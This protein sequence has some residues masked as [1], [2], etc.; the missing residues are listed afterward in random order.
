[1]SSTAIIAPEHIE[2]RILF[3]R[4]TRVML[5]Q[6]LAALYGVTTKAL[7]QAV[8]RNADRFPG[9]FMFR[10]SREEFD[11]LRSQSVTSSWGGRRYPPYA[12][13]EQGVAMLSAVLQSSR[14]VAV[15]IEIVRVFVRLRKLLSEHDALARKLAELETKMTDHD[16][17]FAVVF[18]AIRQ[19]IE[20][21]RSRR[22]KPAIGY[23]TEASPG[24]RKQR[25]R[26]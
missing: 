19:L 11:I 15:S 18:D 22:R 2:Q 14:A 5:D 21:D 26:P 23:H 24:G 8:K 13:T 10:L 7:V 9:D 25:K 16:E 3:V 20:D 1:M 12:F 4:E 6:D 17:K